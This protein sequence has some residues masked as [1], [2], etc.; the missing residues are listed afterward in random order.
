MRYAIHTSIIKHD[1]PLLKTIVSWSDQ[2]LSFSIEINAKIS[3]DRKKRD[4]PG[5]KQESLVP[6]KIAQAPLHPGDCVVKPINSSLPQLDVSVVIDQRA[7]GQEHPTSRYAAERA[8][9][10]QLLQLLDHETFQPKTPLSPPPI[11]PPP[12]GRVLRLNPRLLIFYRLHPYHLVCAISKVME[13][14]HM[15][16]DHGGGGAG[17]N[18]DTIEKTIG[19]FHTMDSKRDDILRVREN[20]D[21]LSDEE[22][23]T[24]EQLMIERI[25]TLEIQNQQLAADHANEQN[26]RRQWQQR[27]DAFEQELTYLRNSIESKAFVLALI[28]GDGSP[29][30]DE[31]LQAGVNG[32]GLAAVRL[33][34]EITKYIGNLFPMS[35]GVNWPVNVLIFANLDGL[36]KKL[37]ACGYISGKDEFTKMIQEFNST[38]HLFNFVDVGRG[39]ERADDRMRGTA[40]TLSEPRD[41]MVADMIAETFRFYFTNPCCKHIIFGGCHD[42]GYDNILRHYKH[43][44]RAMNK[45]S[46]L[47]TIPSHYIYEN[48]PFQKIKFESVFRSEP[49]PEKPQTAMHPAAMAP[50][51]PIIPHYA[52]NPSATSVSPTL[53]A[54]IAH[55]GAP[56][57]VI[58]PS[59]M[60]AAAA[61]PQSAIPQ[62]PIAQATIPHTTTSPA[63]IPQPITRQA[64]MPQAAVQPGVTSV[65]DG[66][67]ARTVSPQNEPTWAIVG[68]NGAANTYSIAPTK[69]F[70][71]K[72]PILY[73]RAGW[74]IDRPL[75]P[76]SKA[77]AQSLWDHINKKGKVC[78]E[79]HLKGA[80]DNGDDCQYLHGTKLDA[81][82]IKAL[83]NRARLLSC[84]DENCTDFDCYQGHHC[85]KDNCGKDDCKFREWHGMDK[86]VVTQINPDGSMVEYKGKQPY[87][88]H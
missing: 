35:A 28:D 11:P 79:Y 87:A 55:G 50:N 10:C 4:Y 2:Q 76:V 1:L 12:L 15:N 38:S 44:P 20:L 9:T 3:I 67:S 62:L 24:L 16:G 51:R 54:A 61:R 31:I 39:K 80:C 77:E 68:K 32:G 29:F 58:A 27:C 36:A 5:L 64:S 52:I 25:H 42:T 34:T 57:S 45:I 78:N 26:S 8:K 41:W 7:T 83:R 47:Q 49:L 63:P 59:P 6:L 74:R 17:L 60:A 30:V 81:G 40:T 65:A 33:H 72:E 18:V 56:Q 21:N 53:Q 22:F 43:D 23:L 66:G 13:T 48:Y 70:Q 37:Y 85:A 14:P 69:S 82:Q 19:D 71:Q 86:H 84:P 75:P 88:G 46:L 73:N